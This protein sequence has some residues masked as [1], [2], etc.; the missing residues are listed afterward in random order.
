V[1][2]SWSFILQLWQGLYIPSLTIWRL[3]IKK[4][5]VCP[6]TNSFEG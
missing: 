2:S 1:T 6:F 4:T 3:C 5:T